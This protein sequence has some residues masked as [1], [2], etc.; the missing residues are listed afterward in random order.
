MGVVCL[1][2]ELQG[3]AVVPEGFAVVVGAHAGCGLGEDEDEDGQVCGLDGDVVLDEER[4]VVLPEIGVKNC[5]FWEA[6][7]V[8]GLTE[9]CVPVL[10]VC[11]RSGVG[12]DEI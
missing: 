11:G 1:A 2:D 10:V 4:D 3:T 8:A 6:C 9:G 12:E 5:A 7:M